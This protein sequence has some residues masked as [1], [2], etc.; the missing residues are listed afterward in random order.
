[1]PRPRKPEAIILL[2]KKKEG[3]KWRIYIKKIR[4]HINSQK[5]V[6]IFAITRIA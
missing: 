1:M 3:R 6:I 5:K 2:K 4:T